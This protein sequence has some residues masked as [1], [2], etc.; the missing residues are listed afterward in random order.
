MKLKRLF[1]KTATLLR[2]RATLLGACAH[3]QEKTGLFWVESTYLAN[4]N[5]RFRVMSFRE[6]VRLIRN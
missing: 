6:L 2:K 1:T 3:L 4:L 5:F